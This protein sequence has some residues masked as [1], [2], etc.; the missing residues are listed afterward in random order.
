[1]DCSMGILW[2]FKIVIADAHQ[3]AEFVLFRLWSLLQL[4]ALG[5]LTSYETRG[6]CQFK[7][8]GDSTFKTGGQYLGMMLSGY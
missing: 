1:M 5:I 4:I 3:C 6:L 2:G 8:N 7:R